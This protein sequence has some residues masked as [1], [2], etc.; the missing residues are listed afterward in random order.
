MPLSASPPSA[1]SPAPARLESIDALR[2]VAVLLVVCGHLWSDGGRTQWPVMSLLGQRLAL[3]VVPYGY[4]GVDLFLVLSGFC[5]SL[6]FLSN[7]G[8]PF[9]LWRYV[10]TRFRRIYPPY[11]FT[12]P[13]L[14]AGGWLLRHVP[15]PDLRTVF[16]AQ[17]L[18]AGSI[19]GGLTLQRTVLAAPFWTLCMEARWYVLFPLVLLFSRRFSALWLLPP[20]LIVT[21]LCP[22]G[23]SSRYTVLIYLP[24]FIAGVFAAEVWTRPDH[25]L[26]KLL[27][28]FVKP[29]LATCVVVLVLF[30]PHSESIKRAALP[31]VLLGL[32]FCFFL[33]LSAVSRRGP[34]PAV[35][36]VLQWIGT[37]SYSLYLIHEPLMEIFSALLHPLNWQPWEKFVFWQGGLLPVLIALSYLFH[38]VFERPFMSSPAPKTERQAEAA[39]IVSP[40]P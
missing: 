18:S 14:L 2:G 9:S 15:N 25:A 36:R 40:A 27:L 20:S 6:P 3:N 16:F 10:R 21:A 12:F 35:L 26:S 39:A 23:F 37:I 8:R 33:T 7:A 22:S 19:V 31:E 30:A 1:K 11:F 13:L 29:A 5:L 38:L 28:R 4:F 17:S 32:V 34:L 24:V